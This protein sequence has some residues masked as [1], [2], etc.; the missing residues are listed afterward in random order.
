MDWVHLDLS[1]ATHTGGLAHVP[2]ETTGFGV[3]YS[4]ALLERLG[5]LGRAAR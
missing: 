2:T 5:W 4:L 1:S 3:R